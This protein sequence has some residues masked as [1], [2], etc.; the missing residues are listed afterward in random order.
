MR[1]LSSEMEVEVETLFN[2]AMRGKW[3]K[4]LEMYQNNPD[5][6]VAKITKSED[7]VLHIA[8]SAGQ[9]NFVT[10]LL[11]NIKDEACLVILNMQNSRGNT[12]L[13]LA[14]DLGNVDICNCIA[15][16]DPKLISC[17]NFEGE[18]PLFLAALSGKKDAFLCLHY[19]QENKDDY[20]ACRKSNGDSVLHCA[21]NG[22]YFGLAIQIIK[23]YPNLTDAIN[24]DGES[25]LHILARKPSCFRSST[26]LEF[27]DSIVY[28]C[29]I[30]DELK[31]EPEEPSNRE[32]GKNFKY[33]LNYET[34]MNFLPM[35][36][37][38][39]GFSMDTKDTKTASDEENPLRK[40]FRIYE[41]T[42]RQNKIHRLPPNWEIMF[43]FLVLLMKAILIVFGV[44]TLWIKKIERKKRKHIWAEQVITELVQHASFYKYE[45]TG[46]NPH[47]FG[48][49]RRENIDSY[50]S[51]EAFSKRLESPILIAART[52]VT[53]IVERIIDT[54]PVAIQDVDSDNK[55][56]LLLS[57]ENR[58]P[59]VYT[60]LTKRK[61]IM[62]NAVFRHVDY[63][64]NSAL[65]LAATYKKYRPWRVPGAAM[66][67]QWEYKWYKLVKDSMPPNF[68][69]RYNKK[70]QTAKEIFINAH[71][72]LVKDGSK[73]MTK[74]SESFSLVAALVATV[75][76][77]TSTAIP[78]G[79]D[80]ETGIP[81]LKGK[82]A[83]SI[84]TVSSVLALCSSVT[85]LV[86][87]LSILTSR[88]QEKDF[89]VDLPR[90]LLFGMT[91]LF[92]SIISV[93]VS[94]C[95]GHIFI[96][97]DKLRYAVYP[98]YAATCLPISFFA[99]VQLPLYFD[100]VCSIFRK[101]PQQSKV[102]SH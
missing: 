64:G 34:C 59:H 44:G 50:M 77:T 47:S 73:W 85:A 68:F 12:P 89:A 93:L 18:T 49:N 96:V 46:R 80:Q 4:V 71:G 92:T 86:L 87:F 30:V 63:Q 1:K 95:A 72:G 57:I 61:L 20:T 55:N 27:F 23:L 10:T 43:R 97:E 6:L 69:A 15:G 29:L 7:T 21:I 58:Q 42:T 66:Q 25:P 9:T 53:E 78:G 101:V 62:E 76:F 38:I 83:F 8:V 5:A 60:L 88:Y 48:H 79:S 102:T 39:K 2:Y 28:K 100:L 99:L 52:G 56:V 3:G 91:S 98:I 75:A 36:M 94:F 17:R 31:D 24:E 54:F 11:D 41:Q 45:H 82:P 67:M 51:R 90:K 65:H 16:R 84:F 33:P 70:G 22:E 14:A 13:H 40:S 81:L 32:H 26:C 19:H 37:K 74:T 35:L